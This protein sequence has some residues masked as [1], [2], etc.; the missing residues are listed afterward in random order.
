MR[1]RG[2]F[3]RHLVQEP[4]CQIEISV[5]GVSKKFF[6]RNAEAVSVA[7][8]RIADTVFRAAA[9]TESVPPAVETVRLM[10]GFFFSETVL[11]GRIQ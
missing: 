5:V 1:G 3:L 2:T 9:V 10:R 4:L 8:L 11:P 6:V 7:G